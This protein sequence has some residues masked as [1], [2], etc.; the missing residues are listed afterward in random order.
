M[1]IYK[2]VTADRI[3]ILEEGFIRFTQPSAFNDP[4][5]MQ[6]FF[7][8]VLSREQVE[9]VCIEAFENE[10]RVQYITRPPEYASLSFDEFKVEMEQMFPELNQILCQT[11][12][13]ALELVRSDDELQYTPNQLFQDFD[14]DIGILC[15][16]E[17]PDNLLMWA[18]YAQQHQGFVIE[19]DEAHSFFNQEKRADYYFDRLLKVRYS[20]DRPNQACIADLTAE[21]TFLTKSKDWE[22]E[23][24]WRMLRRLKTFT[25]RIIIG[26]TD[27]HLYSFP[28][29]CVTGIILGARMSD[30][31]RTEL[32]NL[33]SND[34]RYNH[35][36]LYQATIN[37]RKYIL[38]IKAITFTAKSN[39]SF[40]RSAN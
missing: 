10:L 16:T 13:E 38:D 29:E 7:E 12:D 3:D 31:D 17:K 23:Q 33:I 36:K 1:S 5:E 11:I 30:K 35:V 27:M 14:K 24:E 37:E 25:E 6:P 26:Q 32:I 20:I 18:H 28:P 9:E 22:Y 19:F 8:T 2:Y 4:I 40:N 21:E 39:N 34:L 15:L